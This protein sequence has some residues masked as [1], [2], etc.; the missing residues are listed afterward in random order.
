MKQKRRKLTSHKII[1]HRLPKNKSPK[2][3]IPGEKIVIKYEGIEKIVCYRGVAHDEYE[4][5]SPEDFL[6]Q[7]KAKTIQSQEDRDLAA[8]DPFVLY[9]QQHKVEKGCADPNCRCRALNLEHHLYD[10]D[11]IDKSKKTS[12]ISDL[13]NKY[14]GARGIKTKE[15]WK[16]AVLE[17]INNC[18][19]LCALCHRDKTHKERKGSHLRYSDYNSIDGFLTQ[20]GL[21][22]EP[23]YYIDKEEFRTITR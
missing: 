4:F 21:S 3:L 20:K 17:E 2:P 10:Y 14:M 8:A 5:V 7:K 23:K 22:T 15:K 11:H 6:E 18:Q 16:K 19:V 12:D 9:V 13:M 1:Y